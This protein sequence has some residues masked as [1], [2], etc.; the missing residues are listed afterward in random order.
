[1]FVHGWMQRSSLRSSASLVYGAM[2]GTRAD[3]CSM[4]WLSQLS[5]RL[6]EASRPAQDA[7]VLP[8][9]FLVLH[10]NYE[11]IRDYPISEPTEFCFFFG[12]SSIQ[13]SKHSCP[14]VEQLRAS[15]LGMPPGTE[16]CSCAGVGCSAGWA[17]SHELTRGMRIFCSWFKN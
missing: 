13:I 10:L 2:G 16:P 9:A 17:R 5:T 7:S 8:L 6:S 1:M 15:S 12:K 11:G 3:C 4:H 14:S